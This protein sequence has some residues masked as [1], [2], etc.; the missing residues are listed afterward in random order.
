[1][2]EELFLQGKERICSCMLP[3][4]CKENPVASLPIAAR[5]CSQFPLAVVRFSQEVR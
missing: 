2:V 5:L 1:M 3:Q 4:L